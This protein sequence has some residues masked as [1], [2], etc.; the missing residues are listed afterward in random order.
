MGSPARVPSAL[1]A[2]AI[3]N[4]VLDQVVLSP[5]LGALDLED[6]IPLRAV[7]NAPPVRGYPRTPH[8]GVGAEHLVKVEAVVVI[9]LRVEDPLGAGS[10]ELNSQVLTRVTRFRRIIGL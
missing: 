9:L 6:A 2:F 8:A 3:W 10:A 7:A 4:A 1:G 5:V